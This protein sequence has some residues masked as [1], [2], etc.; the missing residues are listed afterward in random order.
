[1][2]EQRLKLTRDD[3]EEWLFSLPDKQQEFKTLF[4]DKTGV[5]LDYS[6]E[7]LD[8]IEAW[9][10][11]SFEKKED[12]LKEDN[13]HLLDLIVSY[14]GGIFRENLNAKWDIDLENEKN[15]Y[16]R[17]PIITNDQ[18]S[19]PVSPHTLITASIGR[20]KG[21]FISTV[22]KNTIKNLNK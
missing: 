9:L 15:A 8:D 1:M 18:M 22:L 13:K 10:L 12:L 14:V 5:K 11:N 4:F 3:F 20:K 19:V 21:N 7:A 16:Y 2:S 6:I 17:L